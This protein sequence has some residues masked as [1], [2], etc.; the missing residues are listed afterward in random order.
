LQT[1]A[2]S[3]DARD[4]LTAG[5][6]ERVTQ[7]SLGIC[8]EMN[9]PDNFCEIIKVAALLHDY[10]KIGISDSILKKRRSLDP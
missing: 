10:G 5:H 3:I 1:L 4:P 2:A 6:S 8:R 7:Y 9:L